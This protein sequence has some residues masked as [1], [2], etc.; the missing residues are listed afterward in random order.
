MTLVGKSLNMIKTGGTKLN[1][2]ESEIIQKILESKQV[3]GQ[4]RHTNLEE[5]RDI[6][7]KNNV[8]RLLKQNEFQQHK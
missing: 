7:K 3:E 8:L 1:R 4:Y 2:N 6:M 5:I